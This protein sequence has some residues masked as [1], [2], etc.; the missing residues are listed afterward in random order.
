MVV[1]VLTLGALLVAVLAAAWLLFASSDPYRLTITLDNASQLVKGNQV[2][3][4]GVPVGTISKLELG[5]DAQALIELEITDEDLTPLHVGTT[6]EVRST[7]L[8]GISN[9]YVSL[10]P[11]PN[12]EDKIES[13]GSI[14]AADARSEVDL[15]AVLNTL[16]P[17]ALADLRAAVRGLGGLADGRGRELEAAIRALN[18]ALSQTAATTREVVRDEP[19]F[20]RFLVD[21]ARVVSAVAGREEDLDRLVPATGATLSAIASRT[22]ELDSSLQQLPPTLREANTT[23]VNLRALVGDLRPAVREARPVAPLLAETL[24]RLQPVARQGVRVIPALRRLVDRPGREDLIGVLAAMPAL[25]DK[26][27]P[28]FES[29]VETVE[30]ALPHVRVIRPYIPEGMAGLIRAYGGSNGGYYD[31]NGHY[32]RIGFV[33]SGFT[34]APGL[35]SVVLQQPE[36]GGLA[37]YRTFLRNRCPGAATQPHPDRS[38]PYKETPSF[39]CDPEQVPP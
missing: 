34:V 31:A 18:P 7:S 27:V 22:A 19:R 8:S 6:A 9:R 28:A 15:D 1:R 3:V 25:E 39:P 23:L 17:A 20:A 4:G 29:A 30:D 26:A 5:D 13:G 37:G 12:S 2:K 24:R 11:G 35:G 32:Q 21:S 10:T 33:G 38:N 16:D 14:P 36:D